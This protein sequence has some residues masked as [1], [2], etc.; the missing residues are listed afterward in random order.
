MR[1]PNKIGFTLI[2]IIVVVAIIGLLSAL[3]AVALSQAMK[4]GRDGKRKNDV[5]KI[6]R[7]FSLSCYLPNA[8]AGEYDLEE[9]FQ[10]I[11]TK[12][13]QITNFLKS[14]PRDPSV[15]TDS[16]SYYIYKVTARGDKCAIA[17]NLESNGEKVTL[18]LI[19]AL[20]P[21]GGSGVFRSNAVGWNK[22]DKYFQ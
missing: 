19:N 5:S 3:S 8:G 14:A 4:K 7:L 6:G 2:E 11:K 10:E 13:P 9:L 16:R 15:V 1:K 22:T 20:T 17:A 18:P 12:N 21:G